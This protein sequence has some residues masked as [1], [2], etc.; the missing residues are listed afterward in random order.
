MSQNRC[1]LACVGIRPGAI[2]VVGLFC[3]LGGLILPGARSA[4]ASSPAPA[5][6]NVNLTPTAP[7]ADHPVPPATP[8]VTQA[9]PFTPATSV[10]V[11]NTGV[12]ATANA[13]L[14]LEDKAAA[15]TAPPQADQAKSLG[16]DNMTPRERL[17][18]ARHKRTIRLFEEAEVLLVELLAD[19]MPEAIRQFALL[20]LAALAQD[21]NNLSRAQQVYAQFMGK[22]PNDLRIPEVL[23]RQGQVFRQMGLNNMAL[24]KFYAV[25]TSALVLKSDQFDYYANLVL[26]AQTEI[27][28][29]HYQLGKYGEAI[30]F[31]TRLLKQ[32]TGTQDKSGVLYKLNRCQLAMGLFEETVA[33][34]QDYL[35]RYVNGTERPEVQFNLATALKQLGRDNE[36]LQQVLALLSEQRAN[37]NSRPAMWAYW[38]QRTGNVIANQLYREGDYPKA[39][40]I[41]TSLAQLDPTPQWQLPVQYQIGMTYERLMQPQKATETYAG[42]LK[43][44]G[45]FATNM[46]PSLKAVFDM[47]RW[48]VGFIEWQE[49]ADALNRELRTP[50]PAAPAQPLASTP[51]PTPA[52]P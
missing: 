51:N 49:K 25:M 13:D 7:G 2:L 37:A 39:L 35:Q 16:A 44:E 21:Q 20:E 14:P 22:W 11:V 3:C 17:E 43:R 47:A 4:W 10:P 1:A 48:R 40:D 12:V 38:Q 45:E 29:T 15:H 36:A 31:L 27:A 9:I 28:E 18:L 52:I 8:A 46:P 41:Y 5:N 24:T 33:S 42:I 26:R 50:P 34:G 32:D 6:Q 23:L 30:E 19:E